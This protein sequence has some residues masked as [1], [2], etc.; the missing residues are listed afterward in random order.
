M[1]PA[2]FK[3]ERYFARYEFHIRLL[4]C[5]SDVESMPLAELLTYQPGARTDFERLWLGYTESRGN[6]QL[7]EA[8]AALYDRIGPDGILVHAGAQ[9]AVFSFMNCVLEPGDHVIVQFPAYQSHYTVAQAAGA[10]VARWNVDFSNEGAPDPDRLEALI[11]PTTRALIVTTPNNP[12]GYVFDRARLERTVEIARKHGLWLLS[13][14]VYRG[15]ERNAGDRHPSVCDLYERGV[16]LGGLAKV[17]GLAGL[18]IGWTATTDAALIRRLASF[19]DY[20][21]IC[22]SAPS[23]FLALLALRHGDALSERARQITSRNLDLLDD[24]FARNGEL[25]E[26][27]RPRAGTTAFPRYR[28]GD[29]D[30][31]CATLVERAG[32]LLLPSSIFDAGNERVRIGFGRENLPE[33][34]AA[35]E[36]C[37]T[38]R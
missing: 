10:S 2:D 22:N 34:L 21:S 14:E 3:L 12:T 27:Q 37:L 16:S 8:I 15:S 7:L 4:L 38:P 20:L 32:V 18:R 33:A 5:S 1:R 29:T 35:L 31:L 26:W 24:Y 11:R 9:E 23:E 28:R 17:H 6:P 30:E 36:G 13:D 25:W 19:K